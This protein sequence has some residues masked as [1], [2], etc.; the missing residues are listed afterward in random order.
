MS[1]EYYN[2]LFRLDNQNS[3]LIWF[4]GENEPDGVVIDDNGKVPSFHDNE[5]LLNYATSLSLSVSTD[6]A[7]LHNIDTV[8]AFLERK[9]ETV[10]CKN[11][12]EAWNLF[13]DVS[14]SV[15]GNF[16]ID[17]KLTVNIYEKLFWGNN[18]PAVTPDAESYEPIWTKREVKVIREV[19]AVGLSIFREKIIFV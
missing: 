8:S 13:E 14:Q 1:R 3:Y 12:L 19:L 18:I 15:G 7:V 2:L 16:D 4:E 11:F 10:Y 5:D 17:R 6:S 9:D